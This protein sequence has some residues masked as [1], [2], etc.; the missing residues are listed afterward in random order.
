[1]QNLKI[2]YTSAVLSEK[3]HFLHFCFVIQVILQLVIQDVSKFFQCEIASKPWTTFPGS[4]SHFD[5]HISMSK[6]S[7]LYY[8]P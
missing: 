6:A 3:H 4:R 2:H 8:L 7:R 1:M 5:E